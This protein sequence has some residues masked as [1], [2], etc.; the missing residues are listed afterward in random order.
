MG[1][2]LSYWPLIVLLLGVGLVVTLITVVRAH[3]FIALILSAVLIGVLSGPLPGEENSNHFVQAVELAMV[4]FGNVAGQIAWVIALASVLGIALTKSGAAEK[5]VEKFIHV[6]GERYSGLALLLAGFVL[7]IPVFFDTVF[8]LLV[9]IAHSMGR[10]SPHRYMLFILAVGCGAI[11]T[12]SLVPPTPGP[13]IMAETL[14]LNLGFVI[15]AGLAASLIPIALGY[16]FA[17]KINR[18][19]DVKPPAAEMDNTPGPPPALPSFAVSVLPIVVPLILIVMASAADI[20][21]EHLEQKPAVHTFISFIGNKNVSMLFGTI[22]ALW[23][24]ASQRKLNVRDLE[25]EVVY[26]L[27]VAGPIIL[28]TAAGGAFGGMIRHSGIGDTI[29]QLAAS[30][31]AINFILLAWL[32]SAT[33]K[34]AQGSGTVAMIT[35]SGIMAALIGPAGLP[36]HTM[37]ILLAIGF[38]SITLSW[39]NDSAFWVVGKLSGFTEK[40]TLRSWTLTLALMSVAGLIEVLLLAWWLP[41]VG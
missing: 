37:Y 26:P 36:Y 17:M 20:L 18:S 2:S 31:F 7:S 39:M 23:I 8:F 16:T 32:I 25:H 29:Q 27:Q 3:P 34:F 4:E 22:I 28:I 24:L 9:P 19:F 12:H 30:G 14:E 15:V 38:G 41:M 40:Q 10:R 6:F 33:M 11:I 5:I 35:T 13:L 1:N 21:Y